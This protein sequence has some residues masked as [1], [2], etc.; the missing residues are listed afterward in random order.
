M[1]IFIA[2][3]DFKNSLSAIQI[4]K[5]IREGMMESGLKCTCECFP[6]GD[7]GDGTEELIIKQLKGINV[8]SEVHDPLGR[9]IK[10]SFG[11]IDEGKTAVIEMAKASGLRLLS[12]HELDPLKASSY[13]TGELI[14]QALAYGVKTISFS[15]KGRI[16]SSLR[17]NGAAGGTAAGL[18][19]FLNAR[20]V[21]VIDYFLELTDF[22]KA[23][24]KADVVI[25]GE[26][27]I[28]EQTL[29]GKGPFGV[30]R[31]S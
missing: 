22:D 1:L 26:G 23:L 12:A 11:L 29:S 14:N 8:D 5:D 4:A 27:S 13:G 17:F 9:I 10:S 18:H 20:L 2:L 31:R 19:A 16:V 6:I 15:A 7:G 25:T 21:N 30:A 24:R 3:N 28:D